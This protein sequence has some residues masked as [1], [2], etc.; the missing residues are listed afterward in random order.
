[1][2]QFKFQPLSPTQERQKSSG[3]WKFVGCV[4]CSCISVIVVI[5]LLVLALILSISSNQEQAESDNGGRGAEDKPIAAN[6]TV[7]F[8]EFEITFTQLIFPATDEVMAMDI[9]IQ[10]QSNRLPS[11]G[12]DYLLMQYDVDCKYIGCSY[13]ISIHDEDGKVGDKF[14]AYIPDETIGNGDD[15]DESWMVYEFPSDKT[16][17]VIKII[18]KTLLQTLTLW[19]DVPTQAEAE[20]E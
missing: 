14:I 16:P 1:M 11:T 5:P 19:V 15:H 3:T 18:E 4:G 10:G 13:T 9:D 7:I 20:T 17:T 2:S 12:T 8:S 6:E